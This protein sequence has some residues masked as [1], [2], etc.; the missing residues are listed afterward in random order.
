MSEYSRYKVRGYHVDQHGHTN[1]SAYNAFMEDARWQLFENNN[2]A[3]FFSERDLSLT[4][5]N[6]NISY[7]RPCK[8]GDALEV[9]TKVMQIGRSSC[10]VEQTII[11]DGD[12]KR[13]AVAEHVFVL[14]NMKTLKARAIEGTAR[15]KLEQLAQVF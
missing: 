3:E 1:V 5:V 7:H 11:V 10:K 13:V 12:N 9:H 4:L 8:L 6:T 15:E 14:M 2:S